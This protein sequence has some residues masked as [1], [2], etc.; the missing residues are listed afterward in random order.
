MDL[1]VALLRD[2][3][4]AFLDL[5]RENR[6]DHYEE[7]LQPG[8]ILAS[9]GLIWLAGVTVSDVSSVFAAWL[10]GRAE[11]KIILQSGTRT[12]DV[13]GSHSLQEV[14]RIVE[15]AS[16]VGVSVRAMII[17]TG[18]DGEKVLADSTEQN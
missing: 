16:S 11:R 12:I 1:Q 9:G 15:A 7:P 18:N 10:A 2:N 14:E 13:E 3:R 4:A 5:L 6:I 8:A 17:Q